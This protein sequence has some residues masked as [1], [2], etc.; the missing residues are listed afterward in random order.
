MA[1]W[2]SSGTRWQWIVTL[3]L[4]LLGFLLVTQLRAS[5]PLR[6]ETELP[7]VRA[8]D[9]ALLIQHQE[10]ARQALQTEVDELRGK[11]QDYETAAAQG[12]S[13]AETMQRDVI[14]YR[15]LLGS[16]PVEGPG[17]I[18]QLREP[19]NAKGVPS[20]I[21]QAQDLSALVNELFAAGAEAI[22]ING[23]RVLAISGFSQD[24]RG[25]T[26]G[27]LRIRPPYQI[28]AIG[29]SGALQAALSIR[30]GF[31]E[32]FRAVGISVEVTEL[33]ICSFRPARIGCSSA[34]QRQ[35]P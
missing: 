15:L 16:T 20:P 17:I 13:V 28:A 7:T 10:E 34:L 24:E 12:R 33:P 29:D 2:T 11:L 22:D 31:L 25:I 26:V 14:A 5:R 18:I 9:L 8:R 23:V 35:P 32:G 30:G 6:H 1:V 21:L 3:F 19:A 27:R 4:V